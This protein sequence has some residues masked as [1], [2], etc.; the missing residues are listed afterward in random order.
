MSLSGNDKIC[1]TC[2]NE[3]YE[4]KSL[5]QLE[6]ILNYTLSIGEMLMDCASIQVNYLTNINTRLFGTSFFFVKK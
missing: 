4:M 6:Q 1:R 3:S 5:F 2:L